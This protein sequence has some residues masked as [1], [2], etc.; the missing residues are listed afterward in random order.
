M[1]S[2]LGDIKQRSESAERE[3]LLRS[4]I[5]KPKKKRRLFGS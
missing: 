3:A 4:M 1:N 2:K 5:P